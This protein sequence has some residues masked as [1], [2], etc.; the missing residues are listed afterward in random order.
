[1]DMLFDHFTDYQSLQNGF[2]DGFEHIDQKWNY[3]GNLRGCDGN[4]FNLL[5]EVVKYILLL[6]HSNA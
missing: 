3:L 1:M 2:L 5:F 4:C 6:P